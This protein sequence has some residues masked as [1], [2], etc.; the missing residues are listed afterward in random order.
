MS[1]HRRK[2]LE[3]SRVREWT[4]D[5]YWPEDAGWPDE[6]APDDRGLDDR[7]PDD[8][9]WAPDD[10]GL[11]DR[12]PDDRGWARDDRGWARDDRSWVRDD[13]DRRGEREAHTAPL[14]RERPQRP[15]AG[16]WT[17][18]HHWPEDQGWPD[19]HDWLREEQD[20]KLRRGRA[21]AVVTFMVAALF[22]AGLGVYGV[23]RQH[24]AA[25]AAMQDSMSAPCARQ[26]GAAAAR[27]R[28]SSAPGGVTDGSGHPAPVASGP[29][30][31][32]GTPAKASGSASATPRPT[33]SKA[34][35]TTTPT[36]APTPTPTADMTPSPAASTSS[37]PGGP[38]TA[39]T[40]VLAL[41]NQARAQ[42]G[43]PALTDSFAL[44]TSA[45]AHTVVM[46]AGCGLSHQCPGEP[47]LGQRLTTAG[48]QWTSAG[49]NV[50]EGGPEPATTADI[51]ALAV[52]LTQGML[53]ETPPN[54]GHRLNILSS[55][56]RHVGIYVLRNTNG[57][58]WMT[59][60]FS[61]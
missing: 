10:R 4:P 47:P 5:H 12:G 25:V 35:A 23:A 52:S 60:D 48:A 56:F 15:H 17:P 43:L 53:N 28:R 45:L 11:D 38:G 49:E 8:R 21:P 30:A 39:A 22:V 50:G 34:S 58:V 46:A 3:R 1:S 33:P 51:A 44:D 20:D 37:P 61:N 14:R 26:T 7:G 41:M 2:R 6:Q 54:D 42:A 16:E 59:Q 18:D 32:P 31:Q 13:N 27:C 9:G 57:T 40:Q 19:Q 36:P 55:S 29:A 24:Q